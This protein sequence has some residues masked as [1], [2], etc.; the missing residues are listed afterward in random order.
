MPL[1]CRELA[2][3]TEMRVMNDDDEKGAPT[4]LGRVKSTIR[5]TSAGLANRSARLSINK[6][7]A[8]G[9]PRSWALF[10]FGAGGVLGRGDSVMIV[11]RRQS[12]GSNSSKKQQPCI[13][14]Q[15]CSSRLMLRVMDKQKSRLT[16][17]SQTS[18]RSS[19][20]EN[21][22]FSRSALRGVSE[23]DRQRGSFLLG[24]PSP[25]K[26]ALAS[27]K[28]S[29]TVLRSVQRK[30][31]G[32]D[33]PDKPGSQV[34]R[35]SNLAARCIKCFSC[36][37][38]HPPR[39][40]QSTNEIHG[41]GHKSAAARQDRRVSSPMENS[42]AV[43]SSTGSSHEVM[44]AIKRS[45]PV[46]HRRCSGPLGNPRHRSSNVAGGD[47]PR[48]TPRHELSPMPSPTIVPRRHCG[49]VPNCSSSSNTHRESGVLDLDSRDSNEQQ[50]A[51]ASVFED[52][53]RAAGR[54]LRA[55]AMA[56]AAAD[57]AGYQAPT[58]IDLLR[59]ERD[60]S[61]ALGDDSDPL[62]TGSGQVSGRRYPFKKKSAPV[63]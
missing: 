49:T 32:Q 46:V 60:S 23:V 62:S 39:R 1:S 11:T 59:E 22:S 38:P 15:R 37:P 51:H 56:Q 5:R 9:M 40:S 42:H 21:G 61:A 25:V 58:L 34:R 18:R 43:T 30:K 35:V 63:F 6:L 14:N 8:I 54:I 10:P 28:R 24:G 19:S 50:P 44:D 7:G 48:A 29:S 47:D 57:G 31:A 55:S 2:R 16:V 17:E 20:G 26:Q 45:G 52:A 33:G 4:P 53:A 27:V 13:M 36:P 3:V 12:W 41:V